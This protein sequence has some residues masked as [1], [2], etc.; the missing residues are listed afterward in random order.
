MSNDLKINFQD[1]AKEV[2]YF[3]I[4]KIPVIGD[5]YGIHQNVKS[6][7]KNNILE[8]KINEIS[9][10]LRNSPAKSL[11]KIDSRE[12]ELIRNRRDII[13]MISNPKEN[14][15][16]TSNQFLE[17]INILNP[18]DNF[19]TEIR[20]KNLT[21]NSYVSKKRHGISLIFID[22]L[23]GQFIPNF[24]HLILHEGQGF[25]TYTTSFTKELGWARVPCVPNTS[26]QRFRNVEIA[27]VTKV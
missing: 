22:N 4:S 16:A 12:F 7:L 5:I 27:Y 1:Y 21:N 6:N 9:L 20:M 3:L 25:F 11:I 18:S 14:P 26:V 13:G 8:S 15:L 17:N 19:F 10:A 23:T 2:L 24:F